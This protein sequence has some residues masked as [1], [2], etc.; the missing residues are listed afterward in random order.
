LHPNI[1]NAEI[2][3]FM[4]FKDHFSGHAADYAAHRPTYPPALFKWLASLCPDN[5]A[6]WDCGTGNGQAAVALAPHF[7][8]VHAT[9]ASAQQ[10]AQ[11]QPHPR[12][13]YAVASAE[14]SGLPGASVSLAT[15]AQAVHWFDLPHFWQEIRR[16]V[17]PGSIVAVWCYGLT[18]ITPAVDTII[19]HYYQD[20]VG[21]FWPPERHLVESGYRDLPFPF[22]EVA[23]PAFDM[24]ANWTSED[25][26]RYLETWS[27]TKRCQAA[28]QCDPLA[29]ITNELTAAWGTAAR[30]VTW[31]LGMRVGR[32]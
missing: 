21:P 6:A 18:R 30:L 31:P 32:L 8:T 11:A 24:S 28:R 5:T 27:A 3:P 29:T 23:A 12:V 10:I 2:V 19:L 7:T 22:D 20:I 26:L 15:V 14:S 25:L 4:A 16:V 13:R 17:K 9:D 1:G